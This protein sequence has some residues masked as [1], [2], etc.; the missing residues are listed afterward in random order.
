MGTFRF[1]SDLRNHQAIVQPRLYDCLMV[2]QITL[3]TEPHGFDSSGCQGHSYGKADSLYRARRSRRACSES[4]SLRRGRPQW[5]PNIAQARLGAEYIG[6]QGR[7]PEK[8]HAADPPP[9]APAVPALHVGTYNLKSAGWT[10]LTTP[11][12]RQSTS[13]SGRRRPSPSIPPPYLYG[14]GVWRVGSQN[15]S[16]AQGPVL[17]DSDSQAT[18][19][20]PEM[21]LE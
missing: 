10:G 21:P 7:T 16:E 15:F 19:G 12:S 17:R 1:K 11:R 14:P 5:Y 3:N 20:S 13:T 4:L 2:T 9:P 8:C 6:K 18:C